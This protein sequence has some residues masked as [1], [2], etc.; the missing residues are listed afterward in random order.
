MVKLNKNYERSIKN[1]CEKFK[2]EFD[3]LDYHA[4]WD[5]TLTEGENLSY[6][7]SVIEDMSENRIEGQFKVKKKSIKSEKEE[8]SRLDRESIR[9]EEEY[10]EKEFE[11]TLKELKKSNT[12]TIKNYEIPKEYIKSV[13]KGYNKSLIFIGGAGTGKTYLTRQVLIKE[14]SDFIENRGVNSPLALYNFL[15]ENNR[16]DLILVFDDTAG[17]INNP[18]AYSILLNVL[19][20]GF[21]EWNTTSDKLKVPKKF[22]F[23]GKIIF[24][25]NKLSGENTEI[26][27]SRCLVYHLKLRKKDLIKMM[28]IIAKQKHELS[29]EERFKI[30][31]FIKKNT[32]DSTLNFDLRTQQKIES[33]YQYDK[34]NWEKLSKPLLNK[35]DELEL[36]MACVKSNNTMKEAQEE[37]SS[38][39]GGS[40]RKF[41]Y[42][43]Q[44]IYNKK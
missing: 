19:W 25:T 6:L 30:V 8:K 11:K 13:I 32:D 1:Y 41:F 3:L 37:W 42:L 39:C 2:V 38:E 36:L 44:E 26:L 10:T 9:K 20:E 27:K 28:Y 29:K 15:Y 31:D 23:K 21:A 7:K 17:L 35:D 4:L 22:K 43:K 40:R 24:I 16:E 18:N 33:L 34:E 12:Q 5:N 14:K